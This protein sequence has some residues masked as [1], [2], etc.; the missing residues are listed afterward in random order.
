MTKTLLFSLS[1]VMLIGGSAYAASPPAPRF[2]GSG[3]LQ[4]A[5]LQPAAASRFSINAALSTGAPTSTKQ[6]DPPHPLK[7]PISAPRFALS[8]VMSIPGA[9]LTASAPCAVNDLFKNGF[10]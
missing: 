3:S 6:A 2:S 9:A 1:A 10:E 8:A 4:P 5:P 7:S